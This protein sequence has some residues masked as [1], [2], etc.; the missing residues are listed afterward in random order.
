MITITEN[1]KDVQPVTVLTLIGPHETAENIQR[2]SASV[3]RYGLRWLVSKHPT[4]KH[5]IPADIIVDQQLSD[6]A[7]LLD[8]A[9]LRNQLLD[10]AKEA[11]PLNSFLLQLDADEEIA[12]LDLEAINVVGAGNVAVYDSSQRFLGY[13]PRLAVNTRDLR[14]ACP[15]HEIWSPAPN[16][17][18]DENILQLIHHHTPKKIRP[19]YLELMAAH[20]KKLSPADLLDSFNQRLLFYYA[21][22]LYYRRQLPTVYRLAKLLIL[23]QGPYTRDAIHLKILAAPSVAELDPPTCFESA[24]YT[25]YRCFELKQP[26]KILKIYY[27]NSFD[28]PRQRTYNMS[29][30]PGEDLPALYKELALWAYAHTASSKVDAQPV[31]EWVNKYFPGSPT[32]QRLRRDYCDDSHG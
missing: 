15:I 5:Y 9:Y 19:D 23:F 32:A 28:V 25:M 3:Q 27:N 20:V 13:L 17:V 24:T 6:A 12:Y 30:L 31:I 29:L 16:K 8:F 4:V 14:Y 21:R 2:V 7:S 10:L 1:S 22:E 26:Q 11:V 18:I